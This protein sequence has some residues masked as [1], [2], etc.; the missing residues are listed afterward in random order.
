MMVPPI[1]PV[2]SWQGQSPTRPD[3]SVYRRP[4]GGDY[5]QLIA[6]I[7]NAGGGAATTFSLIND[8]ANIPGAPVYLKPNG[9]VGLAKADD[10]STTNVLGVIDTAGL[11]QVSSTLTLTTAQW[12]ALTGQVGGLTVGKWYWLS[13]TVAGK[14]TD[15]EPEVLGHYRV[16]LL[17]G[18]ST[19]EALVA[20]N[21][22]VHIVVSLFVSGSDTLAID[23]VIT[24]NH[25]A[26]LS[27]SDSLSIV[28]SVAFK[29]PIFLSVTDTLSI[30]DT[31]TEVLLPPRFIYFN[32]ASTSLISESKADGT[33]INSIT[34]DQQDPV[35]AVAADPTNDLVYWV[36][37][38]PNVTAR[39]GLARLGIMRLGLLQTNQLRYVGF[40]GG[41]SIGSTIPLK[42]YPITG[43]VVDYAN[44][45]IWQL[46]GASSQALWANQYNSDGT[47][48]AASGNP[49]TP[50]G[51]P[52]GLAIDR[53]N[54]FAGHSP[55][56]YIADNGI[57]GV[58]RASVNYS[59]LSSLVSN[60]T[61]YT[62]SGTLGPVA[63]DG[64]N[65]V[66]FVVDGTKIYSMGL[67][68]FNPTLVV[69]VG[70]TVGA[71]FADRYTQ[72]LY[73]QYGNKVVQSNYD[74]SSPVT[75]LNT[76]DVSNANN[77]FVLAP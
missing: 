54:S 29:H 25:I 27:V 63:C 23:E 41:S 37:F 61:V 50:V 28:D 72:K 53:F 69:N 74:G 12:D 36:S 2:S 48:G 56:L 16:A 24:V 76:P 20:I 51:T 33:S 15:F 7:I 22:P 18:L 47:Q 59:N 11:V 49:Y 73:Y 1:L 62:P 4:D 8:D 30:V 45:Y 58:V 42:S 57:P 60:T 34:T 66:L 70:S 43:L 3:P 67:T 5:E 71:L 46:G 75:I 68:G 13:D 21:A 65:G 17:Y 31:P 77:G 35:V 52:G 32:D 39:L 10:E 38:N 26:A 40:A 44:Q 19:T 14:L 6:E 55:V 64:L 9:H